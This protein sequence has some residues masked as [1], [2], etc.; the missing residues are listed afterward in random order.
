[1]QQTNARVV[2]FDTTLRDGEQGAGASMSLDDK[3]AIAKKLDAMGVDVIEA[4]FP[5]ASEGAYAAVA[6]IA[7]VC[8]QARVCALARSTKAD[9]ATAARA[10]RAAGSRARLHVF[11]ATDSTH[12]A[13]KL[14]RTPEEVLAA[15]A[16]AVAYAKTLVDDIEFSPEVATTS[17]RAFLYRAIDT[18]VRA[19]AT[20]INIPDTTGYALPHE[21]GALVR[22]VVEHLAYNPAIVVS[23]HCHND[24]G[25]ATANTLEGVRA[26]ARQ[27]EC[28]VNGIGERAGNTALE[29]VVM[30]LTL[31]PDV[32]GCTHGVVT[33]E[34]CT[35]SEL[36][37]ATSRVVV[38]PNKAFVG[39]NAF[40]HESG[41]HQAGVVK[42]ASLYEVC[43]PALVGAIRRLPIGKLS[44]KAG[45]QEAL[46]RLGVVCTSGELERIYAAIMEYADQHQ[47]VPDSVITTIARRIAILCFEA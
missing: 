41:I 11:M 9:I 45:V 8:V 24:R 17:D 6:A 18:A 12:M 30:A 40:A 36:V 15:I 34:L 43:D 19:G 35:L 27:V 33:R 2:I 29:E 25:L 1:M 3:V 20:T 16:S 22:D 47:V 32:Y 38:P 42:Q 21:F 5:A 10:I 31:R 4:G 7:T 39:R 13:V 46:T 37:V 28:T 23:V 44:G 26:G 14:S